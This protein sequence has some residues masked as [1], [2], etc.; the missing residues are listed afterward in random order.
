LCTWSV[1]YITVA[2][3]FGLVLATWAGWGYGTQY[4]AGYIVEASLSVDNLLVFVVIMA[5]FAVPREHQQRVLIFGIITALVLRAIFIAL[6]ATLLARIVST[7][8][9]RRD[10][11]LCVGSGRTLMLIPIGLVIIAQ[12]PALAGADLVRSRASPGHRCL[13]RVVGQ[14]DGREG[15][16]VPGLRDYLDRFRPAGAPGAGCTG[17]PADRSRELEGELTAVLALLDGVQAE[18]AGVVAQARRDAERIVATARGEAA[19]VADDADRRA[20]AARDEAAREVLAAARAEAVGTVARAN[21]QA[22]GVRDRARQRLPALASRAV[23]LVRGLGTEP[24]VSA[25]SRPDLPGLP[26]WPP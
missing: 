26:G 25:V 1:F 11:R 24:S 6:G 20:R 10:F 12:R 18:C 19:A 16:K 7:G 3:V 9:R 15:A 14:D 5:A 23:G 8:T 21:Q 13:T 2:G 4:F 22:L 17:V